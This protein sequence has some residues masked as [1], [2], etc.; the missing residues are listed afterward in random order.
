MNCRG[1][2]QAASGADHGL[3]VAPDVPGHA[4]AR[5]K[6][7]QAGLIYRR[8]RRARANL[9]NRRSGRRVDIGIEVADDSCSA[10]SE[11]CRTRSARPRF[12]VYP[13][14]DPPVVL[15]ESSQTSAAASSAGIAQENRPVIRGA[16]KESLLS[17]EKTSRA[18]APWDMHRRHK[19]MSIYSKP[20]LK[21][22]LPR[23]YETVS[24]KIDIAL[25]T[26]GTRPCVSPQDAREAAE[27]DC[28]QPAIERIRYARRHAVAVRPGIPRDQMF[29]SPTRV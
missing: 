19:C 16:L 26:A 27:G 10:L 13:G 9:L 22:C 29:T 21:A 20:N 2:K 14:F 28:R 1:R 12:K 15:N 25:R 18:L 23:K 11:A 3:P 17:V 4:Q 5:R 8:K 6:I 24:T 7:S